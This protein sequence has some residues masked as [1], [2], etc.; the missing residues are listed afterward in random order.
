MTARI[1]HAGCGGERLPQWVYD[2]GIQGEEI[3]LDADERVKPDIVASIDNLGDIGEFDAV[4]CCHC[5]EHLHWSD[6]MVALREFH[7]V[8]KP[9]GAAIIEV[10]NL[11]RVQPDETV[12]YTTPQGLQ[13][14]GMDMYFGHRLFTRDNPFMQHRCGFLPRTMKTALEHAGFRAEVI[15]VGFDIVGIGVK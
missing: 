4:F 8:L 3:R 7:R 5:L 2:I 12:A 11:E 10:P 6:A 13:V 9:G 1:L 14:T 15:K